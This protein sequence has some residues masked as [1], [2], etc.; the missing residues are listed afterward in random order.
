MCGSARPGHD[1]QKCC[2]SWMSTGSP[3]SPRFCFANSTSMHNSLPRY[4]LVDSWLAILALCAFDIKW[5]G[6]EKGSVV[7]QHVS[8]LSV[9][10]V[11][12]SFCASNPGAD[13]SFLHLRHSNGVVAG[14]RPHRD[15]VEQAIHLPRCHVGVELQRACRRRSLQETAP[16]LRSSSRNISGNISESELVHKSYDLCRELPRGT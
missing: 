7:L 11:A 4:S 16:P 8:F 9:R 12:G 10:A 1:A 14:A 2:C 6:E 15:R 3:S 13:A 5:F